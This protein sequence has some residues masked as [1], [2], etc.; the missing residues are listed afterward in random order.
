MNHLKNALV[1]VLV[2]VAIGLGVGIARWLTSSGISTEL[3]YTLDSLQMENDR[4]ALEAALAKRSADSIRSATKARQ[5]ADSIRSAQRLDSLEALI[6]DTATMV[7]RE[8]HEAIVSQLRRDAA[9]WKRDF[10]RA[11]SGW[12]ATQTRVDTLLKLNSSLQFQITNLRE[13]VNPGFWGRAKIAAP[14]VAG[15]IL[16]CKLGALKCSNI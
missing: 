2:A 1:I 7:D 14:F 5:R 13:K 16:A 10:L 15:T 3:A 6:P 4:L 8:V 9:A 11:D 12:A